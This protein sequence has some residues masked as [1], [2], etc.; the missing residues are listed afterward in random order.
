M[1]RTKN[2]GRFSRGKLRLFRS[3][4]GFAGVVP[5]LIL[6]AACLLVIVIG[7]VRSVVLLL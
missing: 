1:T 6:M 2:E 4:P 3:S 7:L 5:M